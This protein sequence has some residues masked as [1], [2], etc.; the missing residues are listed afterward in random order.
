M[1]AQYELLMTTVDAPR[2]VCRRHYDGEDRVDVRELVT[3]VTVRIRAQDI[4]P[5]RHTLLL[6]GTEYQILNVTKQLINGGQ[7]NAH[8]D[9]S[10]C[11]HIESLRCS[12]LVRG[13]KRGISP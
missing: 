3:R 8:N 10:D 2:L 5:Y 11:S 9:L 7:A 6:E 4:S 1:N 13:A 12:A